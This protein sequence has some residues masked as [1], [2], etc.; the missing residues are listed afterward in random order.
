MSKIINEW[1][2]KNY[3]KLKK[4]L[5]GITRNDYDLVDD[6]LNEC[7]LIFIQHKKA[8]EL[9]LKGQAKFF[10]IRI[11]LNQYRSKT[12]DFYRKYKK[13]V[14]IPLNENLTI[15]DKSDYDYDLDELINLNINII[16]DLLKSNIPQERYYGIMV[17]LYFSNGHNFAEV[18]RCLNI[19]RSTIRRQF[20]DATKL[21][22]EKMK[23]KNTNVEYNDLPLKILTTKLLKGYGKGRRF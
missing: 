11:V 20:D 7:L 21:I 4:E 10:F 18:S 8:E 17:M 15:E 1:V 12:S 16:E 22:L 6:L 9:I 13:K 3:E 14:G 23:T 2:E 5:L 19:S